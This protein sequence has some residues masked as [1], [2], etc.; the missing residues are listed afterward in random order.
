MSGL[1][2][3]LE[4]L[5]EIITNGIPYA[6]PSLF[7]GIEVVIKNIKATQQEIEKIA[8]DQTIFKRLKWMKA[9]R[10]LSDI[11]KHKFTLGLQAAVLNLAITTKSIHGN[12][13]VGEKEGNRFRIEAESLIQA[14]QASLQSDNSPC[15][16]PEA[17]NPPVRTTKRYPSPTRQSQI[18]GHGRTEDLYGQSDT[19]R[20]GVHN[21]AVPGQRRHSISGSETAELYSLVTL[22]HK[23]DQESERHGQSNRSGESIA[24]ND[25]E[26]HADPEDGESSRGRRGCDPLSG[27]VAQFGRKFH[28]QGDAA[29]FLY[30]LVFLNEI[31]ARKPDVKE[32]DTSEEEEEEDACFLFETDD[33]RTTVKPRR[34]YRDLQEPRRV[35]NQLL[36]AWT[37]LSESEIEKGHADPQPNSEEDSSIYGTDNSEWESMPQRACQPHRRGPASSAAS[38]DENT[39][40]HHRRPSHGKRVETCKCATCLSRSRRRVPRPARVEVPR[41]AVRPESPFVP[42]AST[43]DEQSVPYAYG[44]HGRPYGPQRGYPTPPH[45]QTA[46][47]QPYFPSP[48]AFPPPPPSTSPPAAT[49]PSPPTS[50]PTRSPSPMPEASPSKPKFQKPHVV[51]LPQADMADS[52]TG[53]VIPKLDITPCMKMTI[54]RQGE[55]SVRNC[56][57]LA[58]QRGIPGKAIMGALVGDRSARNPHGLDLAHT[59]V[60]GQDMKLIYIRGNDLGETWFINEQPVFLQFFH[61]GYLPQFYPASETDHQAMKQEF[62][63]I[64][65]EWASVEALNHLG[66]PT[67]SR[68]EGRVLLDPSTTWVCVF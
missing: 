52:E 55:E 63:A 30:K 60:R 43:P 50:H 42:K 1:T 54:V 49:N 28:I 59:L 44:D 41:P 20:A 65:E 3:T 46:W 53:P 12:S 40:Q 25:L 48:E 51:V 22:G 57:E 29:T 7:E 64:G 45:H 34:R 27:K 68:E 23:F 17:P 39:T 21:L 47:G 24:A 8:S 4:H 33:S 11:E 61:C 35:V 19:S 18:P 66:L 37:S 38:E 62:V 2:V 9:S 15:S 67:K 16:L 26:S 31:P 6:K 14:G 32:D 5:R 36:L 10:L 13:N 56:D 58:S